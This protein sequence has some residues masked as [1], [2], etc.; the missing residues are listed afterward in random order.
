MCFHYVLP[1]PYMSLTRVFAR[2]LVTS[3][4]AGIHLRLHDAI[5]QESNT[6]FQDEVPKILAHS[7]AVVKT[8]LS[9][10]KERSDFV[11]F[12]GKTLVGSYRAAV[13]IGPMKYCRVV[14]I[15][16]YYSRKIVGSACNM[17]DIYVCMYVCV[18]VCVCVCDGTPLPLLLV[19]LC[20]MR[21][22]RKC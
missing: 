6:G 13:E 11:G 17:H 7:P 4:L 19:L 18:C 1:A 2:H 20:S 9:W 12:A 21:L 16:Y 3:R 10:Y 14:I 15:Q 8:M 22:K 5:S